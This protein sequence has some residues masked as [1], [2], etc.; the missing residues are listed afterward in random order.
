MKEV[1]PDK[2]VVWTFADH[3]ALKTIA[4]VQLPDVKGDVTKGEI[5]HWVPSESANQNR[6]VGY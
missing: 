4:S 3:Q 6:I 1:S 2:K 5:A